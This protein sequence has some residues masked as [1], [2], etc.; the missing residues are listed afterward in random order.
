MS[1]DSIL[2]LLSK[3]VKNVFFCASFLPSM[4]VLD[5]KYLQ[6]IDT[7]MRNMNP[8]AEDILCLQSLN[9]KLIR[10]IHTRYI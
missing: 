3:I 6:R 8:V 4:A 7:V 5:S 2:V 10:N 1:Y 9:I